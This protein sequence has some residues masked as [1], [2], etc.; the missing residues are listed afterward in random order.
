MGFHRSERSAR[1]SPLTPFLLAVALSA[2]ER[3]ATGHEFVL[4]DRIPLTHGAKVLGASSGPEVTVY[5]GHPWAHDKRGAVYAVR[6]PEGARSELFKGF[7]P[8]DRLGSRILVEEG[9]SGV[10][11]IVVAAHDRV[12]RRTGEHIDWQVCGDRER[13]FGIALAWVGD[14]NGDG[15]ADIAV[16]QITRHDAPGADLSRGSIHV[17]SGRSGKELFAR[18]GTS[19]AFG[20]TLLAVPD[21]DQDG[22]PELFV[23]EP[24]PQRA[25]LWLCSGRDGRTLGTYGVETQR[26]ASLGGYLGLLPDCNE[27][28]L[29]E[30]LAI[31][32]GPEV[33]AHVFSMGREVP[34]RT[35]VNDD[36]FDNYGACCATGDVDG[37]GVGD[38]AIGAPA[39]NHLL[40]DP[41][42]EAGEEGCLDRGR[43]TVHSG[44]T[45]KVLADLFGEG[46]HVSLGASLLDLGDRDGNGRHELLVQAFHDWR[47]YEVR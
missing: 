41:S 36:L 14:L 31:E 28:G 25:T 16:S 33:R 12:E 40:G 29:P 4:L 35:H 13:I 26:N 42:C 15:D 45:G 47:I 20:A 44:A 1:M 8:G 27:D 6:L 34:L 5:S 7:Q 24:D 30:V 46:P 19:R 10:P 39:R 2:S 43:V 32:T 37:D 17:L 18:V 21:I 3:A 23:G 38:Y 11:T 22:H 9:A